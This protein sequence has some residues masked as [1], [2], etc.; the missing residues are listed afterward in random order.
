MYVYQK[1]IVKNVV[2]NRNQCDCELNEG[3]CSVE[4][5]RDEMAR[6][7]RKYARN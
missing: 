5:S 2:P 4:T 3:V 7:N 6:M 1:N